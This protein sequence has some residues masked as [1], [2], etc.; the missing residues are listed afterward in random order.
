MRS[1]SRRQNERGTTIAEFAVVAL[2]FFTIIFGIIE[3]GRLLN[4]RE[5]L[6]LGLNL[7]ARLGHTPP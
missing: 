3:F 4:S 5:R 6:D 7:K 1:F 2:L